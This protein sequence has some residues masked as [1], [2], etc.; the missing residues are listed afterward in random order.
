MKEC[1]LTLTTWSATVRMILTF[2]LYN[3]AG[4]WPAYAMLHVS[5]FSFLHYSLRVTHLIAHYTHYIAL[6]ATRTMLITPYNPSSSQY[7]FLIAIPIRAECVRERETEGESDRESVVLASPS[8]GLM[9]LSTHTHDCCQVNCI[10]LFFLS[11]IIEIASI[12]R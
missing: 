11:G 1:K 4:R 6:P 5:T 8:T 3:E 2:L 12:S 7:R 9:S 10:K